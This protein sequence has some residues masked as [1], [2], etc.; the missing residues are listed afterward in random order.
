MT[1]ALLGKI[2]VSLIVLVV[3]WFITVMTAGDDWGDGMASFFFL[4]PFLGIVVA[5]ITWL[6]ILPPL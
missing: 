6:Y 3:I 2:F 1:Y 5:V 4:G